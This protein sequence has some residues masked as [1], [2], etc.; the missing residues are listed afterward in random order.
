[1]SPEFDGPPEIDEKRQGTLPCPV[2]AVPMHVEVKQHVEVDVCA[3]HGVWL[4]KD[5][6]E[7]IA[8]AVLARRKT[9]ERAVRRVVV[10]KAKRSER[11]A[12]ASF[13]FWSILF[14]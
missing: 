1:M 12:G 2:C 7:G 11:V 8:Q 6:L 10:E 13:A 5:E 3:E 9:F 14:H 4:D